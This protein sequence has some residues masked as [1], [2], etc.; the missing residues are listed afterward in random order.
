M[1]TTWKPALS[2]TEQPLY[3]A[4]AQAL[5][6]DITGGQ[7]EADT[8]LPTQRELADE[9][10]IAIGTVTRAYAEVERR[11][12]IRGDGRRGTFVGRHQRGR[13]MLA[14]MAQHQLHGIDLSKNHPAYGLDPDLPCTLRYLG[15]GRNAQ[16][17]LEYPPAA[18]LM[19]HREAGAR[20]F[21]S[22]G[23]P[24]DPETMFVTAGAQHGLSVI[25]ASEAKPGD[26]IAA[27][28][29]TYPGIRA[30][31][32]Q[33]GLFVVGLETDEK[34]IIPDSLETLCRHRT[35]R[36]LYTNPTVN[37]PTNSVMPFERREQLAEIASRNGITII[38]DEIMRS[39]QT[40]HPGYIADIFPDHTYL[41]ISASK[42]VAS[43][44]RLGF[45]RAP[46]TAGQRMIESLNAS[47]L[48]VSPISAELFTTWLDDGTVDRVV[49]ER[50]ADAASRQKLAAEI[51]APCKFHGNPASYHIWLELPEHLTSHSL[52]MKTQRRGVMIAPCEVFALDAKTTCEAVR[53]SLTVPSTERVLKSGLETVV[54]LVRGCDSYHCATV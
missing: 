27:E 20:W 54:S 44:I 33:F 41:V 46:L 10:K 51:F 8:R 48:G 40:E 25:L 11:G 35:V 38:E 18:G 43:G 30:L 22:M 52:A 16:A 50:R 42:T 26:T 36:I 49:A 2:A 7:L 21:E 23:T 53:V 29:F 28:K 12:L 39:L 45:V 24:S 32:E 34:G 1:D 19:R 15:R 5:A 31:A 9:L 17:L 13:T 14:A 6:N 47:C 37:N 4:I 3:L